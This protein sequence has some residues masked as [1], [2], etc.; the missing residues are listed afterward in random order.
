MPKTEN[1]LYSESGRAKTEVWVKG[2]SINISPNCTR[3]TPKL[4]FFIPHRPTKLLI[5]PAAC[6]SLKIHEVASRALASLLI[7]EREI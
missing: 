4:S 3:R 7:R 2:E 6:K 1:S 5:E